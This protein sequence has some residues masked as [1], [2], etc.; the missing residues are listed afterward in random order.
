[1][2]LAGSGFLES[3]TIA[4]E[5]EPLEQQA[6]IH[7]EVPIRKSG[8]RIL[9]GLQLPVSP[10]NRNRMYMYPVNAVPWTAGA[11]PEEFI[12]SIAA[13]DCNLGA[14]VRQYCFHDLQACLPALE[15]LGRAL[16]FPQKVRGHGSA[17]SHATG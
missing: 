15:T 7:I 12:Y 2:N 3:R 11:Y 14:E 4:A 9:V 17:I 5:L 8:D 13:K 16:E 1:M 6:E 10:L